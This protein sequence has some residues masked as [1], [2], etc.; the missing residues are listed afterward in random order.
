M[1]PNI[2]III[3]IIVTFQQWTSLIFVRFALGLL[4]K[5]NTI[6]LGVSI[7]GLYHAN[8]AIIVLIIVTFQQW[9]FP[10]LFF[11]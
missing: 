9:A 5:A 10:I 2:A 11:Y 6:R 4:L 8:P 1:H 7:V 3:L